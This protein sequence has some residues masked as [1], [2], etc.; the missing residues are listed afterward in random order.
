MNRMRDLAVVFGVAALM[1]IGMACGGAASEVAGSMA[2]DLRLTFQGVE[3]TGVEVVGAATSNGAIVCC[4]TP[5]NMANMEV[6]GTGVNHHPD[7]D[8]RR[9]YLPTRPRPSRHQRS[10]LGPTLRLRPGSVGNYDAAGL[11]PAPL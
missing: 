4:G 11:T 2:L 10:R 3:C 5:I 6:V 8:D 1:A 7:R 9:V